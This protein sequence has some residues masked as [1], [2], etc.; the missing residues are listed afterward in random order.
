MFRSIQNITAISLISVLASCTNT[1]TKTSGP[2]IKP[3]NAL[4]SSYLV[5]CKNKTVDLEKILTPIISNLKTQK[6]PYAQFPSNEWRDCSGNFLRL[7]SYVVNRCPDQ[8]KNLPAMAGIKDYKAGRSN[9][10]PGKPKARSTKDIAKWYYAQGNFT[11]IFY[12]AKS[13]ISKPSADL[14]KYRNQIRVGTVLWFSHTRP[15]KSNSISTLLSKIN[16]MATVASVNKDTKG[17]VVQFTMYHGRNKGKVATV[18]KEQYWNWP[19][20]FLQG[21]KQYP[22]M[23]YWSQYLVGFASLL[24][25]Q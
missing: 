21:N 11:P 2:T 16:H 8:S 5:Q 20:K 4:P 23:G 3:A 1:N 15:T 12:D 6:I 25:T 17:N 24:P 13:A 22:P 7:C 14:K 18:T 19:N 10:A 9:Q